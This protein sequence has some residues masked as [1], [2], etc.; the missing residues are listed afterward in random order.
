MKG[1]YYVIFIIIGLIFLIN[2]SCSGW[3]EASMNG[4][5]TVPGLAPIYNFLMGILLMLAFTAFMW[6]PLLLVCLLVY[7]QITKK[8]KGTS[9]E[10]SV[11]PP[12]NTL[13]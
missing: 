11:T 7:S 3:N 13:N 2:T 1:K 9:I 10:Q 8:K 6:I 12:D 4:S 5:C